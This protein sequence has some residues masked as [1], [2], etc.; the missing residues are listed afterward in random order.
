[1]PSNNDDRLKPVKPTITIIFIGVKINRTLKVHFVVKN[2]NHDYIY[3][4]PRG[5]LFCFRDWNE[6]AVMGIRN[7]D[8]EIKREKL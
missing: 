2:P 5:F 8:W 6:N 7:G 3:P 1:M 4:G